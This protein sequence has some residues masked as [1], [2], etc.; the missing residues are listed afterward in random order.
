MRKNPF[1]KVHQLVGQDSFEQA[2]WCGQF[3]CQLVRVV[4]RRNRNPT[5]KHAASC[6]DGSGGCGVSWWITVFACVEPAIP[7]QVRV[8]YQTCL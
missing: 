8:A 7:Y 6:A 5:H 1:A 4:R 2:R 3:L